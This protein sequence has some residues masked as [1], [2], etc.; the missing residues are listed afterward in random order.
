MIS[1]GKSRVCDFK[2]E[3][4]QYLKKYYDIDRPGVTDEELKA[5]AEKKIDI[6]ASKGYYIPF[7]VSDTITMNTVKTLLYG[8]RYGL[9]LYKPEEYAPMAAQIDQFIEHPEEFV[10][11]GQIT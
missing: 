3:Q 9:T 2:I 4:I 6:F 7:A 5:E 8:W 1:E 11:P 10:I